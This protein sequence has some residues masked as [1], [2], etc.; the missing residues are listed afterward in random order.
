MDTNEINTKIEQGDQFLELA[1]KEMNRPAEDVVPYMVCRSVRKSIAYYLS[2]F[3][4]KNEVKLND[5]ETVEVLL[6]KCQAINNTFNNIDLT[7]ITFTKD[8]EYTAEINQLENCIDLATYIKELIR[9]K[10]LK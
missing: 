3:L 7:P 9:N 4:L 6:K 10:I 1:Q 2:G 8:Y 5:E